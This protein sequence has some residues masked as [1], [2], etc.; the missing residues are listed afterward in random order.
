MSFDISIT[1]LSIGLLVFMT[2][3]MAAWLSRLLVCLHVEMSACLSERLSVS[4]RLCLCLPVS[5][6]VLMCCNIPLCFSSWTPIYSSNCPSVCLF[7]RL[8]VLPSVSVGEWK[9]SELVSAVIKVRRRI[10]ILWWIW[11]GSWPSRFWCIRFETHIHRLVPEQ[12]LLA[13][14]NDKSCT[15]EGL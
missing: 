3:C 1:C 9:I 2:V 5:V 14:L 4:V 6:F 10:N 15:R 13:W 11:S 12:V 8:A 7:V